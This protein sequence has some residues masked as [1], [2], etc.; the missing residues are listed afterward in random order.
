[1]KFNA[2]SVK[3]S[4]LTLGFMLE[5]KQKAEGMDPGLIMIRNQDGE[6]IGKFKIKTGAAAVGCPDRYA[7]GPLSGPHIEKD[8]RITKSI[9]I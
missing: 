1:M 4:W 6:T 2:A 3:G 5:I 8:D 9:T 7:I